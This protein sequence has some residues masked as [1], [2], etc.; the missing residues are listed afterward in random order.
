MEYYISYIN[1]LNKTYSSR[2]YP[3]FNKPQLVK[4]IENYRETIDFPSN[5]TFYN[6]EKA[7]DFQ[8]IKDI[9]SYNITT[10]IEFTILENGN[11]LWRGFFYPFQVAFDN[12][13]CTCEVKA[14]VKD[15]YFCYNKNKDID[16]NIFK[17]INPSNPY[18]IINPY[19]LETF[20]SISNYTNVSL[21]DANGQQTC[22][23]A[24]LWR[25]DSNGNLDTSQHQ[26][27]TYLPY[28]MVY[29]D[30]YSG[31]ANP[32]HDTHAAY[33]PSTLLSSKNFNTQSFLYYSSYN[34]Q[35]IINQHRILK[36]T[37]IFSNWHFAE[38][39]GNWN[40]MFGK[41]QVIT[42]W[43]ME[44][45]WTLN[46][47]LTGAAVMP[48][49]VWWTILVEN[50]TSQFG[51]LASK[52]GRSPYAEYWNSNPSKYTQ[53]SLDNINCNSSTY[54]L[55]NPYN[56]QTNGF[57]NIT[58]G[59]DLK[60]ILNYFAGVC[61]LT[62]KSKFFF[63]QI[64]PITGLNNLRYTIN[65]ITDLRVPDALSPATLLNIN[66]EDLLTDLQNIFN[67]FFIIK[68]NEIIIE[69][70]EYFEN[71]GSYN[72]ITIPIIDVRGLINKETNKAEIIRTNKYNYD[73]NSIVKKETWS[74]S[75]YTYA[76]FAPLSVIYDINVNET[77][78]TFASKLITDITSIYQLN[79]A[80][81]HDS[82]VLIGVAPTNS[83]TA[84]FDAA[85]T[86]MD[87][88]VGITVLNGHLSTYNI[89]KY[90]FQNYRI[91]INAL[92]SNRNITFE[93]EIKKILQQIKLKDCNYLFLQ[94][95]NKIETNLGT[96]KIEEATYDM[97]TK[98]TE[99]KL[100]M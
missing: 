79:D 54:S 44:T 50:N 22:V 83:S 42:T 14:E 84:Y 28:Y 24:I 88:Y 80:Y 52:W 17:Y 23:E 6:N 11:L 9:E 64:N 69:H 46:D 97:I 26:L 67:V 40:L 19:N 90:Y 61:G 32:Y 91:F 48:S 73:T 5:I 89:I 59:R 58:R 100:K 30:P 27:E 45:T 86:E 34:L 39:R 92:I 95:S 35:G 51:V 41:V 49:G 60:D 96:G 47:P 31:G 98:T 36:N 72:T 4:K 43:A 16:I 33:D 66:F 29:Y 62:V 74:Y 20:E 81:S 56:D 18:K 63:D 1:S 3:L 68:G 85:N 25:I 15:D 7:N 77:E 12:D 94:T 75:D 82:I 71:G 53:Y 13:N 87:D 38:S 2:V 78:K 55:T 70:Q 99:L 57:A 21:S 8:K 76:S 37:L 10:E 93:S 65:N